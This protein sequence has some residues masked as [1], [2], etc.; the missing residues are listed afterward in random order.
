MM[1]RKHPRARHDAEIVD[2][3][4]ISPIEVD[5]SH[6]ACKIRQSS[7]TIQCR[8]AL[9]PLVFCGAATAGS[10][11]TAATVRRRGQSW[12]TGFAAPSPTGTDSG[13][14]S[15]SWRSRHWP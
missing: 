14:C 6:A 15:Q 12:I 10:F 1:E 7:A 4:E 5:A 9:I 2:V 8:K 3:P 11:G 13:C